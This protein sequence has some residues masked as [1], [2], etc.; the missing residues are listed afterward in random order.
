MVT[1]KSVK[2]NDL[3]DVITQLVFANRGAAFSFQLAFEEKR[4][5][6]GGSIFDHYTSWKKPESINLAK[7]KEALPQEITIK[8]IGNNQLLGKE[9]TFTE[10]R[11][12]TFD[13]YVPENYS[14]S[15]FRSTFS[16]DG[17]AFF[18]HLMQQ[19][20]DLVRNLLT[21]FIKEKA[22]IIEKDGILTFVPYDS[23]TL[24]RFSDMRLEPLN[25]VAECYGLARAFVE[26]LRL[27]PSFFDGYT[28][29]SMTYHP[30]TRLSGEGISLGFDCIEKKE[31][32][33]LQKW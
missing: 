5:Y 17:D 8:Q 9:A 30:K 2:S 1:I 21:N 24:I 26:M 15:C 7:L 27:Y 23:D 20:A 11:G 4:V 25:S 33:K 14:F 6:T 16:S 3:P 32:A 28:F 10:V 31:T 18:D 29:K 22:F 13:C 12:K 19:K